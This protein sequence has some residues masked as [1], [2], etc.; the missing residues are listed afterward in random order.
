MN[1]SGI[2]LGLAR[3]P[4]RSLRQAHTDSG[5]GHPTNPQTISAIVVVDI[6]LFEGYPTTAR[7]S[8]SSLRSSSSS[9]LPTPPHPQVCGNKASFWLA[10]PYGLGSAAGVAFGHGRRRRA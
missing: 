8:S 6:K 2:R 9:S 5:P 3:P 10:S 4:L 1:S 7:R